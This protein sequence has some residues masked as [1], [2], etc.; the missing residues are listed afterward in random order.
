MA[1]IG[2]D[3]EA[4]ACIRVESRMSKPTATLNNPKLFAAN[5]PDAVMDFS[6]AAEAYAKAG[7]K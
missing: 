7:S 4:V 2:V 5:H 6:V 1:E 3:R